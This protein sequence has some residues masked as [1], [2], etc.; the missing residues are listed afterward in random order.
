MQLDDTMDWTELSA[1]HSNTVHLSAVVDGMNF[2]PNASESQRL[3]QAT[4]VAEPAGAL[5]KSNDEVLEQEAV[6]SS[7][8]LFWRAGDSNAYLSNWHKSP[9]LIGGRHFTCV[10]QYYMFR[11]AALFGDTN[12]VRL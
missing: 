5:S 11:K 7:P 10:E 4:F 1:H 12:G 8:V 2:A 9:M 6:A 3:Q